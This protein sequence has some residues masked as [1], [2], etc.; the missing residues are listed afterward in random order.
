MYR[1]TLFAVLTCMPNLNFTIRY[2]EGKSFHDDM[3][4]LIKKTSRM[5]IMTH[6][7]SVQL[8]K[9]VCTILMLVMWLCNNLLL[10]VLRRN[11]NFQVYVECDNDKCNNIRK[12]P[13]LVKLCRV[14]S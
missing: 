6:E 2:Y 12:R 14:V 5:Y 11:H 1:H 3:N 8:C 4:I 9:F 13:A 7:Q 10:H